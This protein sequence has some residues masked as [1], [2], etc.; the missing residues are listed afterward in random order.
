MP[1]EVNT[2]ITTSLPLQTTDS[3]LFIGAED[4]MS[5]EACAIRTKRRSVIGKEGVPSVLLWEVRDRNGNPLDLTGILGYLTSSVADGQLIFRFNDATGASPAIM[6]VIGEVIDPTIGQ[7]KVQ[8]PDELVC[9][10]GIYFMDV[11][12]TDGVTAHV[13]DSG[14]LSIERSLFGDITQLTG[15][16]TLGELRMKMLDYVEINDLL[17]SYEFSDSDLID[18]IV[19]PVRDWNETPP[20][21]AR[22]S[23]GNFP[24]HNHWVDAIV[25]E[26]MGR[27][28]LWAVRNRL[29]ATAGNVNTD[30]KGNLIENYT[31]LRRDLKAQWDE[32][33]ARK[34]VEIN[35]ALCFGSVGSHYS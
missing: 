2:N 28:I 19:Y 8:L 4:D 25:A 7:S 35:V 9:S 11:A 30:D 33:K 26:L 17:Q 1:I 3:P 18:A 23:T 10:P 6:Q 32:F 24:Y 14:L 22:F 21:V 31:K 34:K 29:N 16:P 13:I 5:P 15:P 12:V 27:K 20:D